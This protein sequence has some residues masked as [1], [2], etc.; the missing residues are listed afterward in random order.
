[1]ILATEN[2]AFLAA[3]HAIRPIDNMAVLILN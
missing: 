1:M 3:L 2:L